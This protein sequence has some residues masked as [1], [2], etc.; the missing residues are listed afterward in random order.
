MQKITPCLSFDHKSEEAANHYLAIFKNSRIVGV[1][2][3][4]EAGHEIHGRPAGTVMTL[5]FELDGQRFTALN[6]GPH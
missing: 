5:A 4:G 6:G 3:Y 2:R 1:T